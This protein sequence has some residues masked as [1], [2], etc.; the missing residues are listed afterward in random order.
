VCGEIERERGKERERETYVVFELMFFTV[1]CEIMNEESK[2][3]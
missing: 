3:C 2:L 1:V